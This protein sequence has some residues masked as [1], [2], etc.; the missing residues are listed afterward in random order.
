ML[1]KEHEGF[2]SSGRADNFEI[3]WCVE[4]V[5]TDVAVMCIEQLCFYCQRSR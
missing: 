2:D 3:R 4:N 5:V 1:S